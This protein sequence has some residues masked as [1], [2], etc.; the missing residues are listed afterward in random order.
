MVKTT[1][2]ACST[3]PRDPNCGPFLVNDSRFEDIAHIQFST[4]YYMY[5]K[6]EKEMEEEEE[7]EEEEEDEEEEE[8][9]EKE[10]KLPNIQI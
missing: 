7:E 10:E 2:Y 3:C 6:W 5:V 9:E 1:L 4:D 8:E